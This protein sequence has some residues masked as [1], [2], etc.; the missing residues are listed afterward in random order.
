MSFF[1]SWTGTLGGF[2]NDDHYLLHVHVNNNYQQ[3][4]IHVKHKVEYA[5]S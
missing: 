2:Y 4:I 3:F 5:A 1:L